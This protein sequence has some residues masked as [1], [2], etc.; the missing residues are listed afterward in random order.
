MVCRKLPSLCSVAVSSEAPS[1]RGEISKRA[2]LRDLPERGTRSVRIGSEISKS[3]LSSWTVTA[4]SSTPSGNSDA[5][6]KGAAASA[7]ACWRD[8]DVEG[9]RVPLP[10]CEAWSRGLVL[11]RDVDPSLPPAG[12]VASGSTARW[13][14]SLLADQ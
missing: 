7:S 2:L 6:A 13:G 3:A 11:E 10:G 12:A 8:V 5:S 1:C 9:E 4:T 14:G